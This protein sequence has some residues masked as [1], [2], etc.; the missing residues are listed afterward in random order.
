V[1]CTNNGVTAKEHLF[2]GMSSQAWTR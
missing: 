1:D 2:F